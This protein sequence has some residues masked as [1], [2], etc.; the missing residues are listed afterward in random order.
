MT[1][2]SSVY[3]VCKCKIWKW[4]IYA[5]SLIVIWFIKADLDAK[6]IIKNGKHY[7]Y[8]KNKIKFKKNYCI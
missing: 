8:L 1:E 7:P 4:D 2:N 3:N 6:K 5:T